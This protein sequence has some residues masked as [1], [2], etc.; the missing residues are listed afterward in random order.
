MAVHARRQ[1]PSASFTSIRSSDGK[2]VTHCD[3][4]DAQ[5]SRAALGVGIKARLNLA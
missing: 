2:H 3:T 1:E 4:S 5:V